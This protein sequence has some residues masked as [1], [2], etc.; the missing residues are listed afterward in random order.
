MT[1]YIDRYYL[2]WELYGI[3][4]A[5]WGGWRQPWANTIAYY[6]FDWDILDYSGNWWNLTAWPTSYTTLSSWIKTAYF[7]WV[8]RWNWPKALQPIVF[9]GWDL[10][11]SM[12]VNPWSN[13]ARVFYFE[14]TLSFRFAEIIIYNNKLE[15]DF[16]NGS[17]AAQ[18]FDV[19]ATN[20]QG[21]WCN[22][23]LTYNSNSWIWTWSKNWDQLATKSWIF[24]PTWQNW[25]IFSIWYTS[26]TSWSSNEDTLSEL[27][28][29]NKTR[30]EQERADYYNQT[31]SLYW[32]S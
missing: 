20:T 26:L 10:T 15:F 16:G 19:S 18:V 24:Y 31:K 7:Q 13:P 2:N 23:V 22:I 17:N 1:K 12:W 8:N 11:I 21:V 27:I 14:W 32:I 4:F 9:S 5:G 29:E 3:K 25:N 6:K 28:I 30:T